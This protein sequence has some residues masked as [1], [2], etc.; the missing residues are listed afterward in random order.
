MGDELRATLEARREVGT[1]LE[2]QLV[3]RFVDRLEKEI[4]RRIDERLPQRRHHSSAPVPWGSPTP[5][6]LGS[7]ALAIPLLGIAG[8][9]AGFPG[10]LLVC[11][12]IVL[13][14]YFWSTRR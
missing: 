9:T 13:V 12:A 11:L 10:V 1:E 4:D 14:N 8:G 7:L 2:P 6:A 3:E 5:L